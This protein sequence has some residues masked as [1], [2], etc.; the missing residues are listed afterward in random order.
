MPNENN[1]KAVPTIRTPKAL[2][3]AAP[4]LRVPDKR[5]VSGTRLVPMDKVVVPPANTAK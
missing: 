5:I 1:S 4:I 2:S 3:T